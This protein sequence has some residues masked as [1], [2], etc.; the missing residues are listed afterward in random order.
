MTRGVVGDGAAPGPGP[1]AGPVGVY[2]GSFSPPTVA[3]LAVA[4]AAR[5]RAG[6]ARLDL[7]VSRR[8]LG[9]EGS[10][11][12]GPE[13]RLEVLLAVAA[14][15]PWLGVRLSDHRLVA[16]LAAGYDVVVMG[17]DK[18]A[19]VR[20]PAWYGGSVT[21]R[22]AALARLP[23]VLVAPRD[24]HPRSAAALAPAEPLDLDAAHGPV[25]SSAVRAG[26]L[27]WML[28]EAAAWARRHAAWGV[29]GAPPATP[30]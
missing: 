22:D 3:H 21:E 10:R 18:W 23:R 26:R 5:A 6:L 14:S 2:P 20:D 4:E 12:P 24:G 16:D 11:G 28:P 30:V 8:A 27:E 25:S 17:A 15:R 19:Q 1:G 13:Q 9:K 29:A 7:V